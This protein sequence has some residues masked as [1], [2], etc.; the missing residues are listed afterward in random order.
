MGKSVWNM[1]YSAQTWPFQFDKFVYNELQRVEFCYSNLL[2][3]EFM[4]IYIGLEGI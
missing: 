3:K 2:S 1:N 4:E